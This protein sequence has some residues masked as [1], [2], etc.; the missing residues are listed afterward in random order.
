MNADEGIWMALKKMLMICGPSHEATLLKE[1]M[2][3]EAEQAVG[4]QVVMRLALGPETP[5]APPWIG[6]ELKNMKLGIGENERG[7]DGLTLI[8]EAIQF[9]AKWLGNGDAATPMGALEAHGK[10]ILD[11]AEK[12][13][14]A[15]E[16]VAEAITQ[17]SISR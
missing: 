15:L 2:K 6:R 1:W 7:K 9:G 5:E 3:S 11:A 10:A 12:I 17:S 4:R 13:A 16:G 14:G 8:A